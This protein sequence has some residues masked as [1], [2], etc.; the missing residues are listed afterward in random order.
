MRDGVRATVEIKGA[1]QRFL[2]VAA[3][4]PPQLSAL[5]PRVRS[6]LESSPR[7]GLLDV[8]V[9]VEGLPT[10]GLLAPDPKLVKSYVEAWRKIGH[11]LG[12]AG[13][14]DLKTLAAMPHLFTEMDGTYSEK[15]WPAVEAAVRAAAAAFDRMR[16][17][18][19][20][21]LAKD[22]KKRLDQVESIVRRIAKL[23]RTF[24][25]EVAKK[26]RERVQAVIDGMGQSSVRV[27]RPNLEREIA[28]LVSRADVS[29]EL[30]RL[31]SHIRQFRETLTSGS[32]A[33]RKLEFL[34]QELERESST[35]GAKVADPSAGRAAVEL[36]SELEKIR[37]QVQNIE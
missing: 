11:E 23:S 27:S 5:E 26:L 31:N 22:L 10:M 19:G 7:R 14:V 15:A 24:K 32:P 18:E 1:N 37:E 2:R 3:K 17:V 35:L 29:E 25:K 4:L 16:K 36:R 20:A 12:L 6:L 30:T 28:I 21:A 8:T 9:M 33:G 13:D 34:V